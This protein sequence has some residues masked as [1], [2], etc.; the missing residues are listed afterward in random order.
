[1]S[2]RRRLTIIICLVSLLAGGCIQIPE[3]LV[4]LPTGTTFVVRGTAAVIDSGGPCPVWFGENGI[5]YHL[6]QDPQLDNDIYDVVTTPGTTSRLVVATRAD[7]LVSC[8]TGTIVEVQ[9][10]LEIVE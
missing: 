9:D 5:T 4:L 2:A 1:M 3:D 10:V 7:L 6:F 8:Q